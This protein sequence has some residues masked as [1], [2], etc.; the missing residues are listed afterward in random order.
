MPIQQ[1]RPLPMFMCLSVSYDLESEGQE[2]GKQ[3]IW[4]HKGE[5]RSQNLLAVVRF[6]NWHLRASMGRI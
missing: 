5:P 4:G 2:D 3:S 1:D 6:D